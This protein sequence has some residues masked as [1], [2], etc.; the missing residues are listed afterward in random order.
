MEKSIVKETNTWK[1]EKPKRVANPC[2]AKKILSHKATINGGGGSTIVST[3]FAHINNM[4]WAPNL[5]KHLR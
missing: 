2:M 1:K 3:Y 4:M 5:I